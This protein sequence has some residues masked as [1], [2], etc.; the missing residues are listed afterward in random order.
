MENST[1]ANFYQGSQSNQLIAPVNLKSL[2]SSLTKKE[3]LDDKVEKALNQVVDD[4][5]SEVLD[6]ACRLAKH[7]GS[8]NLG[9]NDVRVAFEK[10]LK[11][12]VP[13]S[14]PPQASG[15]SSQM[16]PLPASAA[17][18]NLQSMAMME[19]S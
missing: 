17:V 9:R 19:A 13:F 15:P 16:L 2:T 8:K 4:A 3:S 6:L 7:R 1:N 10:R 18:S 12:R 11:M 14:R 5:L